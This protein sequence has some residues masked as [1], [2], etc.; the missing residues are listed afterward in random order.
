MKKHLF[1]AFFFLAGFTFREAGAQGI[2]VSQVEIAKEDV[3]KDTTVENEVIDEI[4]H[5]KKIPQKDKVEYFSQLTRYGF[6]NLFSSFSYNP[7]LP[8]SSQVNP[9]AESYMQDYLRGHSKSLIKMRDWGTPYFNLIDNIFAQYG[10]PRELKYLAVI[11][12]NLSTAATSWVGAGGPWQ[13]MPY[14]AR[15]YGLVVN[16]SFDERRDYYKSTHAAARYLLTLYKQMNKDWLLVIAAYNGGPG[17]VFSAM[18][19]SGSKNFWNLQYYLPEESRNHVKKFI[20]THYIMEGAGSNGSSPEFNNGFQTYN[21]AVSNPYNNKPSLS[22]AEMETAETQNISGKFNSVIIAK[23]ISMDIAAFN[24]YNPGFDN[25]LS[26]N[27]Q[28]ELILPTDKMQLF[29]AGKYQILNEC[30]QYLLGDYNIP[31]NKTVYPARY[32]RSK[33][34]SS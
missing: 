12:S 23:N 31:A 29:M 28:Y 3:T 7:K 30:V 20:A 24:R 32:N 10:L 27:G 25:L 6:K 19:R 13:F 17:R 21:A 9:Y 14:T 11:E 15:D 22:V 5:D 2:P 16:A 33:K 1:I 26:T 8:Y 18:K 34:K 4:V